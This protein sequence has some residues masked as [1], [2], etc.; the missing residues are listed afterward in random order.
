MR[1]G[2]RPRSSGPDGRTSL[3]LVAALYKSAFTDATVKAGEIGP[4]DPFYTAMH[5]EMPGWAPAAPVVA[6]EVSA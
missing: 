4:G 3:E 2:E 6:Q 1:A 5:G